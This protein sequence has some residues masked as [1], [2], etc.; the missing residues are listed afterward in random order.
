MMEPSIAID[1]FWLPKSASNHAKDFDFAWNAVMYI[2]VFFFFLVIGLTA[3]FVYKYRRRSEDQKTSSIDHNLKLEIA[4]TVI[5]TALVIGLFFIGLSGYVNASVAPANALEINAT[6]Q[7]WSWSFSYPNGRKSPGELVIPKGKPVK[8]VMSSTDVLHG[9]FIPEFRV[10][11][12]VVPGSYTTI[13]FEA[14]EVK[15]TALFCSHYCGTSH[16]DMLA[17]VKVLEEQDFEKWLNAKKYP[18]MSPEAIGEKL[19]VKVACNTCHSL[20]N[21]AGTGPALNGVFGTM[22]PLNNGSQVMADENYIRESILQPQ[23]KIVKGFQ[24]VMPSFQGQLDEEEINGLIAYLKSK[25]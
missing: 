5:P 25:K 6:A 21:V 2:S 3:Y 17:T 19:F 13:W 24:P 8:M 9:F 4:W 23:A 18:G 7:K 16:S 1:S 15:E 11:R 20:N 12:D 22:Q 10:K 14:T